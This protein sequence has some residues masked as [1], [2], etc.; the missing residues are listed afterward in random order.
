[1]LV[2]LFSPPNKTISLLYVEDAIES[3]QFCVIHIAKLFV[4]V[5]E[6]FVSF[7]KKCLKKIIISKWAKYSKQVDL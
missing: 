7:Q 1:M 6:M 3:R 4:H 5:V 2:Q